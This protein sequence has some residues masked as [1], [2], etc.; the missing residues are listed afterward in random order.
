[1][2]T[3]LLPKLLIII[4]VAMAISENITAQVGFNTATHQAG[5]FF[6]IE[7]TVKGLRPR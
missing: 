5:S 4:L 2:K 1:M 6:G 3:N 7:S